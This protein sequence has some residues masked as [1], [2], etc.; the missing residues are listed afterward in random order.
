MQLRT[1]LQEMEKSLDPISRVRSYM[2]QLKPKGDGAI[3]TDGVSSWAKAQME[4]SP[5]ILPSL[6]FH[7]L[8]FGQGLSIILF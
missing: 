8:V 2:A 4:E 7:D 1:Q 5:L 3:S 6:K